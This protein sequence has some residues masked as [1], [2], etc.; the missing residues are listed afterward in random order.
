MVRPDGTFDIRGIGPGRFTLTA[1]FPSPAEGAAWK[2]RAATAGARNLVDEAIDLGPGI[3]LRDVV[4]KFT[5]EVT[6]LSGTLQSASGQLV[7][8]YY[9]VAIPTDRSLW[10]PR[11]RR[12]LS[13]RPATD[14]R[15][16]FTDLL[17][18]EYTI[19][20]L[21]DLDPIDLWDN[22]ILTQIAAA[23]APVTVAD[24][25]KKVHDLRIR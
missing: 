7:T 23:G 19:A 1:S 11:S 16:V 24:G 20:A 15:F 10:R 17:A 22:A 25:E 8:E 9:I 12:I 6:Q 14:G 4:V 18:G 5:D 2:L 13:V 3:D 21:T